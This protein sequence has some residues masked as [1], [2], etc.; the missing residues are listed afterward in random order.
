MID[1]K[2]KILLLFPAIFFTVVCNC[3]SEIKDEVENSGMRPF[4]ILRSAKISEKSGDLF[5]AIDYYKIYN[6][7]KPNKAKIE[8]KL[9]LLLLHEKNYAKA[10]EFL[11]KSYESKPSDYKINLF[12]YAQ[13]LQSMGEYDEAKKSFEKFVEVARRDSDLRDIVRLARSLIEGIV[14]IELIRQENPDVAVSLLDTA[15]NKAHIEFS[16]LPFGDD[17]LIFGSLRE[18]E[19]R[20]F[21]PL[22]DE[23]PVRKLFVAQRINNKWKFLG[24]FGE[25]INHNTIHTGNGAFSFDKKRFYFSRCEKNYAYQT[26]CKILVSRLE[27][28]EWQV[29]VELPEIINLPFTIS[30][31]PTLGISRNNTDM[32]YFVSD[33]P[34]GRGGLDLWFTYY[35][36]RR[37][38]WREP[39]NLGR[40]I[41][42]PGDEITPYYNIETK[43]LY[44]SSNGHP[45]FGG[46]DIFKAT[47]EARNWEGV[48]NIGEPINSSFDD[49]YYV[50][51][52]N[53]SRG[54]FTSNRPG[55]YSLRHPSCCDDIYEFTYRDFIIIAAKGEVFGIT[56]TAFFNSIYKDYTMDMILNIDISD[57][58]DQI[59]LLYDYPVS[60]FM[61][62]NENGQD[63]FI[64]TDYTTPGYY[65]FNLEQGKDYY[66]KVKDFNNMEVKIDFTTKN[67]FRSDTIILDAIII[68]TLPTDPI[69]VKNV[70]YEF[71]SADLTPEARKT[72]QNTIFKVMKDYPNIILEISS[73]TDSI[74]TKESNILLSQ[75]RAHSVVNYLFEN[76]ITKDRLIPKGYGEDKPIAP[77]SKPDG[78]DNPEGRAMNRR[79]EFR[80]IGVVQDYIDVIY[81]D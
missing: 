73:H 10:A 60:L 47:G 16:P 75:K 5:S 65:F 6:E 25:N 77:N 70:Y 45:G 13:C 63:I 17:K 66:L 2:L 76:G 9:G 50:L 44:F 26:V 32:L 40:K 11:L 30:T 28:N 56:D 27:N 59:K 41:N 36:N 43:T 81:E 34:E 3:Q 61:K 37:D 23:V 14:S 4:Q 64:R 18:D 33:R 67:I 21:D 39:R 20:Y 58:D 53:R 15:V 55:G 29:P 8:S 69:I 72:L 68:N 80:I 22:I 42:T 31:M 54:F 35:D 52:D 51:H 7:L 19:L 38:E 46:F 48:F 49:Q 79:T 74:G 12:Y 57:K 1:F 78:S 71:A 24:E 62:N